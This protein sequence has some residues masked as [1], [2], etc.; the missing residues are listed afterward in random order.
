MQQ[1]LS[2]I[3]KNL[4]KTTSKELHKAALR[5]C[6][7]VDKQK[8]DPED[9][10]YQYDNPK[11]ALASSCNH[12]FSY[13]ASFTDTSDTIAHLQELT[14][15][16]FRES[17]IAAVSTVLD[18]VENCEPEILAGVLNHSAW[19]FADFNDVFCLLSWVDPADPS[20]KDDLLTS[21]AD[22]S[23]HPE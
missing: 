6:W 23:D 9:I 18:E 7:I 3:L 21:F 13:G 22:V 10:D 4:K 15:T 2:E 16:E 14:P 19:V 5:H 20:L 8:P 17:T 12:F 11:C 1:R